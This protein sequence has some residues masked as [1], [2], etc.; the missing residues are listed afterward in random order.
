M[1][2]KKAILNEHNIRF[3]I[4]ENR[5]F[6]DMQLSGENTGLEFEDLTDMSEPQ[7]YAWLGY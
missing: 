7:L 5:L 4:F 2:N 3:F 1:K 6:A